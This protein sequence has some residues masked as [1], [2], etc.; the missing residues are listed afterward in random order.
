MQGVTG[1][2]NLP[3]WGV[4][5]DPCFSL[6]HSAWPAVISRVGNSA[7]FSASRSFVVWPLVVVLLRIYI[8]TKH[9]I[10]IYVYLGVFV[11]Q[12]WPFGLQFKVKHEVM[13]S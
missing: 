8:L 5:P 4:T 7:A 11:S 10:F 13:F 1:S 9:V 3:L 6:F 12:P 2:L